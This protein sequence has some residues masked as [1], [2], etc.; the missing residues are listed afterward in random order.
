MT[1]AD[2]GIHSVKTSLV[3]LFWIGVALLIMYLFDWFDLVKERTN[4]FADGILAFIAIFAFLYV[5]NFFRAPAIIQ[6]ETDERV[7]ELEGQL[8]DR[9]AR[10]AAIDTLWQLRS[11]GISLRNRDGKHGTETVTT[12]AQWQTEYNEWR[13][14][15]L[16]SAREINVNLHNWLERLDRTVLNPPN[17]TYFDLEHERLTR[18]MSTMLDRMQRYLEK[19]LI[20]PEGNT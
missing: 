11:E 19:D 14:A 13:T 15:V 20:W 16:N 3:K 10:Q 18:I 7:D 4:E 12:F 9:A 17:L 8:D 1:R 5:F 2:V 6:A